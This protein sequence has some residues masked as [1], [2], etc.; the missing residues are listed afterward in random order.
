MERILCLLVGYVFGFFHTVYLYSK[1]HHVDIRKEGSGNS[2]ST[3]VLRV[4]GVKAGAIV[5]FGDFFKTLIPC[6]IVRLVFVDKPEMVNL[7]VIYTALGVILGHNY[8]FYMGFK[9]GKGIAATAGL[10]V[11]I[12]LRVTLVCLIVFAAIVATTRFVSLGSL[13]VVSIFL[14][15]MIFFG[16]RG[17]YGLAASYLP[18]F[19]AVSAVVT[20][21]AFWRHRTN[22]VRLVHGNENKIGLK[23]K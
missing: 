11:A 20:G 22:I 1:M 4:M 9:G 2:G 10:L 17:D 14:A 16:Q 18:E 6:I 21:M 19:Y 15:L 7:L 5:F 12:D 13:V 3:N 8:P 23:K